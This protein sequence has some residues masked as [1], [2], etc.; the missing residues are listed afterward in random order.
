MTRN[1]LCLFISNNEMYKV[2]TFRMIYRFG[3]GRLIQNDTN[4]ISFQSSGQCVYNMC[5]LSAFN[6]KCIGQI[7]F[8]SAYL[9]KSSKLFCSIFCISS[10]ERAGNK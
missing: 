4:E 8:W 2:Y 7:D 9:L 3:F 1:T 10:I 5:V 6:V